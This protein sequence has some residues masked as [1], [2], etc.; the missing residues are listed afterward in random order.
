ML[1]PEQA[2]ALEQLL[3]RHLGIQ[4]RPVRGELDSR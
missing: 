2:L 4:D 3:E 1:S